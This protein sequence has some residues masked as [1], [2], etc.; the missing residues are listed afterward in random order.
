MYYDNARLEMDDGNVNLYVWTGKY[1]LAQDG[2]KWQLKQM[3][4]QGLIRRVV[5]DKGRHWEIVEK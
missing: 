5:P 4:Q 1:I 3:Q 2:I